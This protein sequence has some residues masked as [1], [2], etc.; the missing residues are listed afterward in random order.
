[1]TKVFCIRVRLGVVLEKHWTDAAA[2]AAMQAQ[3]AEYT[4]VTTEQWAALDL[5][6]TAP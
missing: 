2:F 4:E 6:D 5:G 1:M 3:S